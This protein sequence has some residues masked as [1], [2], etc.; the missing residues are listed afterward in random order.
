MRFPAASVTLM[1]DEH[2]S[3]LPEFNTL[4]DN[5]QI[6]GLLPFSLKLDVWLAVVWLLLNGGDY[7]P[8]SIIRSMEKT[9]TNCPARQIRFYNQPKGTSGKCLAGQD[10]DA[11]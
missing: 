9:R 5:K 4:F 6:Q 10:I 1:M 2:S 7:Y 3:A 8:S 11:A